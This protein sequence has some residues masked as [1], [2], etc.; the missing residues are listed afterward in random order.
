LDACSVS[1][2]GQAS[3]WW[4]WEINCSTSFSS[5][6]ESRP[7]PRFSFPGVTLPERPSRLPTAYLSSQR[8]LLE[9]SLS[10]E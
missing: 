1:A 4:I 3:A 6:P 2:A 7:S 5:A 10:F 9:V 8:R